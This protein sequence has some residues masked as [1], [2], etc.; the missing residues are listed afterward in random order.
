MTET[1]TDRERKEIIEKCSK[2]I[3]KYTKTFSSNSYLT[4]IGN[5]SLKC[6]LI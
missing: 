2:M 1:E 3:L 4:L 6:L 5:P